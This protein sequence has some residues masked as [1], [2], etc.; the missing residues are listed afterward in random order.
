V[1]RAAHRDRLLAATEA[2]F[3]KVEHMVEARHL[4]DPAMIGVRVGKVI[5]KRK[6]GKHFLTSI[7]NGAFT[8]ARDQQAID[9]EAA[10]D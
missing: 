6:V 3:T 8:W 4:T 10:F 7:G 9:T 2:E 5:N 1:K